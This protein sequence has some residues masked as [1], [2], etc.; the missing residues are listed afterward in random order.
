MFFHA[1]QCSVQLCS[2]SA[3]C[4]YKQGNEIRMSF[5]ILRSDNCIKCLKLVTGLQ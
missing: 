5:F 4:K 3:I 2:I 1:M